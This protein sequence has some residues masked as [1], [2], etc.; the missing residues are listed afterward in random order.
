MV[1]LLDVKCEFA[2]RCFGLDPVPD[3][4]PVMQVGRYEASR[5]AQIPGTRSD[6]LDREAIVVCPG[7]VRQ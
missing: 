3:R 5:G 1:V 6:P 7:S 2:R 4:E